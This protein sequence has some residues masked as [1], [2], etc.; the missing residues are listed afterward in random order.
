MTTFLD[1]AMPIDPAKLRVAL[2]SGNY[3]YCADGVALVLN[4]LVAY[5]LTRGVRVEVFAPTSRTP[6]LQHAGTLVSVPSVTFP[7]NSNYRVA[8]G[9]PKRTRRRIRDF[10][11][12]LFHLA[13]PDALGFAA[14]RFARGPTAAARRRGLGFQ[15][16]QLLRTS[17]VGHVSSASS[18][19]RYRPWCPASGESRMESNH[20]GNG[21]WHK[22]S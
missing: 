21:T 13:S 7:L 22:W 2:F 20:T 14:L 1:P 15:R 18:W 5:L 9:I 10:Q 12:H 17:S 4:R 3:N 19:V 6:A 16:L 8:W 11:P